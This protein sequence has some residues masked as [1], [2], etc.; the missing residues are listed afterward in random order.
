M[1]RSSFLWG[2]TGAMAAMLTSGCTGA[3]TQPLGS[4]RADILRR[5]IEYGNGPVTNGTV[6][7][8]KNFNGKN[9]N[10]KNFNGKNFNGV[11]AQAQ[12]AESGPTLVA[13]D[14]EDGQPMSGAGFIGAEMQGRLSDGT[15]AT[16]R[17]HAFDNTTVPGMDLFLVK[18]TATGEPICGYKDGQP[19]WA[20]VMP[21]LYDPSSGAQLPYDPSEF[22][23]GCRFG[24]I[25]KCQEYGYP[26]DKKAKERK[27]GVD[28][29]RRFNDYHGSCVRMVRADYCGDGVP[30][31]FDGTEIDIYDHLWNNNA[32][33][34]S[35][36]G[37]DGFYLEADWDD[38]GAHCI[39][40]TRWMPN[41]LS[42]LSG[43]QSS[44]NPDW[45]YIRTHCPQRFAYSVPLVG[46]GMSTPDRS[47]GASSNWNTSVGY[48]LFAADTSA[49]A[50]RGK[51]R[52]NSRL[53]QYTP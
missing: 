27:N 29:V 33:A 26:K 12:S 36:D 52:N 39:N 41:N 53:Y 14:V 6:P 40:K 47:C 1:K 16:V 28:R 19:I 37:S 32:Q 3:D 45:E 31:T 38:D 20:S 43:N 51:I 48:D 22:T 35:T 24:G 8:G 9:F 25:Q 7:N 10:G 42:G 30:H 21:E 11:T 49:Q 15:T 4:S 17:V 2:L 18:Y 46:G 13:I 50:G 23:F 44:S 34:T 5:Y